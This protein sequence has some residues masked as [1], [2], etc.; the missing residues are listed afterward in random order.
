MTEKTT[1][2]VPAE[3]GLYTL[4]LRGR[5]VHSP[6]NPHGE[7]QRQ[8]AY[9]KGHPGAVSVVFGLGAGYH[10]QA[11]IEDDP[12]ALA[13]VFEPDPEVPALFETLPQARQDF[14]RRV[15][16]ATDPEQFS[17]MLQETVLDERPAAP[18]LRFIHPV[19]GRLFPKASARFTQ[20]LD[21]VFTHK[22]SNLTTLDELLPYWLAMIEHNFPYCIHLPEAT[23]LAGRLTGLPVLVVGAG[24]SLDEVLPTLS[25]LA[26]RFLVVAASS[27][28]KPLAEAGVQP[29]LVVALD[30][31]H[32]GPWL[33]N[34]YLADSVLVAASTSHPE[35]FTYRSLATAVFH[36]RPWLNR[37]FGSGATLATG[38]HAGSAAFTLALWSGANPIILVGQDLSFRPEATHARGVHAGGPDLTPDDLGGQAFTDA[39]GDERLMS[40]AMVAYLGWYARAAKYI[41]E[42]HPAV[43][44]FNLSSG[45]AIPGFTRLLPDKLIKYASRNVPRPH[46]V[47]ELLD[48]P[49]PDPDN[50]SQELFLLGLEIE[51]L[52]K[53]AGR[54]LGERFAVLAETME[55]QPLFADVFQLAYLSFQQDPT[56]QALA[57]D[58]DRL[59]AGLKMFISALQ[60]ERDRM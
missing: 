6:R 49:R 7:A 31:R 2:I 50:I 24:P 19:Y 25:G 38:G 42:N 8:V 46:Q 10:I 59:L 54:P 9:L 52:E 57:L 34:D 30:S 56:N 45:A 32:L 17:L 18:C 37:I 13:L 5:H 41:R 58:L 35:T 29:H 21:M 36:I 15:R 48:P 47:A 12:E 55:A 11:L 43:K 16:I 14:A 28:L 53:H 22:R 51:N 23:S 39:Q 27:A 4:R 44:L 40:P 1:D 3:D 33:D 20:T 60:V 26:G